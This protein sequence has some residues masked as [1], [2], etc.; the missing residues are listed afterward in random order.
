MAQSAETSFAEVIGDLILMTL[1]TGIL[2][3]IT[4]Q[5]FVLRSRMW[6][7]PIFIANI[8]SLSMGF[9]FGGLAIAFLVTILGRS[10]PSKIVLAISIINFLIPVTVS[11]VLFIRLLAVYPPRTLSKTRLVLVY[12]PFLLGLLARCVMAG[13]IW[14]KTVAGIEDSETSLELWQVTWTLPYPKVEWGL[15]LFCDT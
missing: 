6:R 15:E 1:C 14:W 8:C 5:L 11:V 9:V 13:L 7:S 12:A 10:V 4:I 2:I 3:P